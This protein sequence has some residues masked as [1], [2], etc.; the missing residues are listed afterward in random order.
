MLFISHRGNLEG[1]IPEL[2]NSP[3]YIDSAIKQGFDVEVDLRVFEE[4]L[5][6]GHD[7]P[8]Y[9]ISQ[10]FLQDRKLNL[11]VHCKDIQAFDIALML[12]LN[13]FWHDTDDYTMTSLRYVW[14]YPGKPAVGSKCIIVM[15]EKFINIENVNLNKCFGVCSDYV[16]TIKEL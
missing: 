13:C 8:Q 11:W 5:Y 4:A 16:K 14:A 7:K 1:S 10:E 12:G 9:N 3:N 2:E 15:P 6:L